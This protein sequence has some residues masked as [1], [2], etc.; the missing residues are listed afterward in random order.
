WELIDRAD[1]VHSGIDLDFDIALRL[2][3][4]EQ[5]LRIFVT[6]DELDSGTRQRAEDSQLRAGL[7][8]ELLRN[9]DFDVGVRIDLPPVAFATVKGSRE[10]R[11]GSWDFYPL[12][13]LFAETRQSV[14]Y[15]AATTFDRW[16][17][18]QLVRSSTFAK[19]RH[20]RDQTEWSQTF[21]Y[22]HA[23]EL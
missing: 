22:A 4:L 6:S 3:N 13:K 20:D 16:S 10:Y 11:L 2:P 21:V 17:G 7:R 12:A 14:G 8:Y 19:W 1:G 23:D 15:A 18:R 9:L 5:R